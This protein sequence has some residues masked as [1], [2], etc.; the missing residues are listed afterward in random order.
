MRC[1]H[2]RTKLFFERGIRSVQPRILRIRILRARIRGFASQFRWGVGAIHRS[3]DW[4]DRQC[5]ANGRRSRFTTF[6]L[7]QERSPVD[8]CNYD[9]TGWR[10]DRQTE[11]SQQILRK[12]RIVE[13]TISANKIKFEQKLIRNRLFKISHGGSDVKLLR[14]WKVSNVDSDVQMEP[15]QTVVNSLVIFSW[16]QDTLQCFGK[17][18]TSLMML[19]YSHEVDYLKFFLENCKR[20]K[21]L[22]DK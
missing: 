22:E 9:H 7:Y 3:V 20:A 12:A 17:C 15:A 16:L 4:A 8:L 5:L 2:R 14:C 19:F 18:F 6:K 11:W 13:I 10:M 1:L 21:L